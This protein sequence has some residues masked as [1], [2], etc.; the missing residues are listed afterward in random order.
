MTFTAFK[1]DAN[2]FINREYFILVIASEG[3]QVV[4]SARGTNDKPSKIEFD[5]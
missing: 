1:N 5:K 2:F 4:F 3:T